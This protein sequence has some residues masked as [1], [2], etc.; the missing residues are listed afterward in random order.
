MKISTIQINNF[1]SIEKIDLSLEKF[2][3]FV[4]QNNHGKTNIFEAIE[5]FYKNT[6]EIEE[7][8]NK[9]TKGQISVIIEYSDAEEGLTNL[10]DEK[11]K[12]TIGKYIKNNLIKIQRI[13]SAKV[14]QFWDYEAN[15]WK[16]NPTGFDPAIN[17]FLP[18]L[19]YVKTSNVLKEVSVYKKGTPITQMLAGVLNSIL[20]EEQKYQDFKLKFNELF[21]NKD[22][23]IR[24]ELDKIS[25]KVKGYLEK[26]FPDCT[27]VEFKIQEPIFEDLLKN[28][29]TTVDDGTRTT[30]E[31]KGDGMQRALML[32]ILQTYCDYRKNNDAKAKDFI[33]LIDEGELHLH[34]TAHRKLKEALVELA[35]KGDQVLINTHSSVLITDNNAI[36]KIFKVHKSSRITD[37]QPI[38]DTEKFSIV[39]E[40]LGGT[41]NDLL[42]PSNFII[43][44]GQSDY[45]FITILL[46]RF[47][48]DKNPIRVLYAEGQPERQVKFLDALDTVYKTLYTNVVYKGKPV[49]LCDKPSN[50]AYK[51]KLGEF[52]KAYKL[53][54]DKNVFELPYGNLEE[55][56]PK[57]YLPPQGISD[58]EKV[59]IAQK[60]AN[61]ITK[62][63]L[64][65]EMTVINNTIIKAIELGYK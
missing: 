41:P 27:E 63:E 36:Q 56:Y 39:Y 10:K 38:S 59:N 34:P 20:E 42:F 2:N 6:G 31:E 55:Y 58:L 16:D 37:V 5:W 12:S 18:K 45:H 15:E 23:K 26:Q 7:I 53:E 60:I 1:R 13:E 28:F 64:E 54:F 57:K 33:F 61:K 30:A 46:N 65:N 51:T 19:E 22:S 43:V 48:A 8:R 24:Q 50:E 25:I 49:I 40:M 35:E 9:K 11:K 62:E 44:E 4:G 17:D 47:F 21:A 3:L 32:A 29:D 14:R 52:M